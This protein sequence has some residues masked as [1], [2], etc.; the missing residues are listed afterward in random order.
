M[1]GLQILDA[2]ASLFL[3]LS[4]LR[5]LHGALAVDLLLGYHGSRSECGIPCSNGVH[6]LPGRQAKPAKRQIYVIPV[7]YKFPPGKKIRGLEDSY[8]T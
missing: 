3:S 4:H 5:S 6:S 8:F 7:N 1:L 2:S